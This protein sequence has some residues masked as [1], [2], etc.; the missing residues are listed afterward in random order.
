MRNY[1]EFK[2]RRDRLA[3]KIAGNVAI[4]ANAKESIRNK[5]CHYPFRSDS[6]FHYLSGFPEPETVLMIFGGKNP[7]S[8]IFC[9]PKDELKEVWNGFIYGPK[10][11]SREFLFEEAYPLTEAHKLIPK[12]FSEL[13]EGNKIKLAPILEIAINK[14]CIQGELF[15]GLW[16]D[17]GTPERLNMINL[18]E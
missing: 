5:D 17:V 12:F 18:D 7:K 15:E 9:Q 13:T 2:N 10:Q 11:A 1:K 14:K 16:S 6:T 3:T 4:V 8:I